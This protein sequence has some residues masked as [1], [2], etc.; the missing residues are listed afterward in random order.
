MA[1]PS[2]NAAKMFPFHAVFVL[3]LEV[4]VFVCVLEATASCMAM[5]ALDPL[6]PTTACCL[7][8][9]TPFPPSSL[10]GSRPGPDDSRNDS[11]KN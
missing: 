2:L 7:E 1:R 3:D 11:M 4:V 6:A 9:R 8:S 10:S 5:R